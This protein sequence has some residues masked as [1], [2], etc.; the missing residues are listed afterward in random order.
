MV[1]AADPY[2]RNLGFRNCY[3]F[4]ELKYKRL[5]L[6]GSHVYDCSSD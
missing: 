4:F 5:R 1:S 3:T 2:G 6:G